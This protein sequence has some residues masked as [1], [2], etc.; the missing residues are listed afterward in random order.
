M[1]YE[2]VMDL[3]NF[4]FYH[5]HFDKINQEI[6]Y[7]DDINHIYNSSFNKNVYLYFHFSTDLK[8]LGFFLLTIFDLN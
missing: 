1:L 5:I 2:N 7:N 8:M 6:L 4:Y 3:L